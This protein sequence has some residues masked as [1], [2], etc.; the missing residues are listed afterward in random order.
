MNGFE[1]SKRLSLKKGGKTLKSISL[2]E[3]FTEVF[4]II[5]M[6]VYEPIQLK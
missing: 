5:E 3:F 1:H 6:V 2:G 4:F